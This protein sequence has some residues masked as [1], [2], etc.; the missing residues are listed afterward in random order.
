MKSKFFIKYLKVLRV[1]VL[2]ILFNCI[3]SNISISQ[4]ITGFSPLNGNVGATVSITGNGFNI[5]P[6]NNVVFF[7]ASKANV[8]NANATSLTVAVPMG[9]IYSPITV[10]NLASGLS[11][12]SSKYFNPTFSPNK[13]LIKNDDIFWTLF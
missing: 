7:G 12:T 1:N 5:T 10:L 2:V 4:I 13:G 6:S 9:A 11:F 8:L 3:F